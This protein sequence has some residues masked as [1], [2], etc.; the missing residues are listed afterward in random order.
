M[1]RIAKAK[2]T[3]S[4]AFKKDSHF[5]F[6]YEANIAMLLYDKGYATKKNRNKIADEILTLIFNN[7]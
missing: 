1:N 5:R 4:D 3:I 2:K 6:G 7:K